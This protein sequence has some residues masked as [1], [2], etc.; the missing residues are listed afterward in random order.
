MGIE[1][2]ETVRLPP[3]GEA[4]SWGPG[5]GGVRGGSILTSTTNE[6]CRGG[7]PE[8]WGW[9]DEASWGFLT[10]SC[11]TSSVHPALWKLSVSGAAGRSEQVIAR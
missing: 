3:C 4:L 8:G 1:A 11:S 9:A 5:G 2:P 10:G 6:G 7:A